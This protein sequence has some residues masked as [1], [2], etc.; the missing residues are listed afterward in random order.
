MILKATTSL[1]EGSVAGVSPAE[2]RG[3]GGRAPIRMK[4]IC[5]E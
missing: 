3:L 4:V 5:D 1:P 2:R